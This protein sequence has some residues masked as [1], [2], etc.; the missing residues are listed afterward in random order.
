MVSS[1]NRI[2]ACL[3]FL[4]TMAMLSLEVSLTRIF[5]YI[6]DY[7]FTYL[8]ISIAMLGFGAAGTYLTIRKKLDETP[9][10]NEF[11]GKMAALLALTAI[12]AIAFIP[13]IH[14][15]PMDM[16]FQK[17]YS[18]LLS[19][20]VIVIL[21][22]SPF[23]FGGVCVAYIISG[24][25]KDINH[26]YF[27]DLAGAAVG[28][29][30]VIVLIN[31]IGAIAACFGVAV[32]ALLAAVISSTSRRSQY[33]AGLLIVLVLT[34]AVAW[35]EPLPLYAP[36]YKQLFGK[37]HLVEQIDWNIIT[38]LDITRPVEVYYSFGGALSQHYD[39]E[40]QKIRTIYQD[41]SALTGIIQPT[42]TPEQTPSLGY[43][44][45]GAPYKVKANADALVI[46]CGGGV[47]MLIALYHHARHVVGVDIN[48]DMIKLIRQYDE[49]ARGVFQRKDVELV[50]AEGRHFLSRD[51][52]KYDVIQLSGVDTFSALSTGAYALSENF[53]YTTEALEQYFTHLK[54]D[55]IVNIS[56]AYF[57]PPRE[58]LKMI[59]MW[60]QVL[61]KLGVKNPEQH[62]MILNGRGQYR[63]KIED[64]W[65]KEEGPWAQTLVKRS[66][67][68]PE[69]VETLTKWTEWLGFEVIYDPYTSR[70]SELETLITSGAEQ[71]QRIINGHRFNI[72][73]ATDDKPFFFRFHRWDHLLRMAPFCRG[74]VR[75]PLALLILLGSLGIVTVLSAAFIIYPL[76]RH[77][78][79]AKAGGRAG[80][81]IYFAALGLAFILIEI[82][83]IQKLTVFLGG[84]SYSMSITLFTILLA[85]GF[86]SFLSRNLSSRPFRLLT[87][88]IPLLVALVVAELFF[89]NRAIPHLMYLSHPLRA[90]TVVAALGPLA[91]LMGMPFPAGLRHVDNYR[92]ELNP[93]A[94]GINACATVMGAV[95]CILISSSLGFTM[96]LLIGAV[97]Y[98]I[99]WATFALSRPHAA[100]QT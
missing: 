22:G 10:G 47:D 74:G 41:A 93:W 85:S 46:G 99:G 88:V 27:A 76:Y 13:R 37:E 92:P 66:P 38:R 69:E 90:L 77:G 35:T 12:T 67:F 32:L 81:F 7:H 70:N 15:Y 89:V 68:T 48:P 87:V 6:M 23:F 82:T 18:N 80:I 42:P 55:G 16:Y 4:L 71:R 11:I 83:L 2:R 45:Q 30:L 24:A 94:W 36:T 39:G 31:W 65:K 100:L 79:A 72:S 86:G 60:M 17:D 73:P 57:T 5:S 61:E 19:M 75:P 44:L 40:P 29:L 26:V 56:R 59:V 20:L 33:L 50:V 51:Q 63:M 28:C 95:L 91:I 64:C 49:F 34:T 62:I 8:V 84:P 97:V 14:F 25:G 54:D 52:R 1:K 96:A 21:A 53:I 3:V 58:T 9:N 98:L 78:S 43:Y